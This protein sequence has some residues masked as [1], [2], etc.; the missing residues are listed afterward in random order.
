M[1]V[2]LLMACGE[3]EDTGTPEVEEPLP[4]VAWSF[5]AEVIDF[6]SVE[7]GSTGLAQVVLTNTGGDTLLLGDL[8]SMHEDVDITAPGVFTLKPDEEATLELSWSP[9]E[10]GT[11]DTVV[12]LEVGGGPTDFELIEM[13]VTGQADGADLQL[14]VEAIDFGTVTVGCT[15]TE[16]IELLNLGTTPLTLTDLSTDYAPEFELVHD[17]LPLTIEPNGLASLEVIYTPVQTTSNVT[18]LYIETDDPFE[19]VASIA[20]DGAGWIEADNEMYWEAKERQPLTILMNINEIAIYQT[21]AGKLKNSIETFFEQLDEFDVKFRM[22]CFL[23]ESGTHQVETETWIDDTMSYEESVDIFYEM[24]EGTSTYGDNDYNM[25]TLDAALEENEEWLFEGEFE[26]SKLNFFTINDDADASQLSASV[27]VNKWYG[28]KEDSE[29]IQV[30]AI[31]GVYEGG[32]TCGEVYF[33]NYDDAISLTGGVFL[34]ICE[35]DWT[36]HMIDV[37]NAFIGEIQQFELTGHPSASTIEVYWDGIPQFDG[38]EYDEEDNE[39]VFDQT[40][41]PPDGTTVRVYYIMATECPG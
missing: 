9:G 21:H 17:E 2:I 14:A 41:Y 15:G 24:L 40:S 19:P 12:W 26:D 8:G 11:L 29:D 33:N 25:Q 36:D 23:H 7:L 32:S 35:S 27:Y 16:T 4:D 20:V 10:T 34:D 38:W 13:D 37:A 18:T 6:G 39:V 22:A 31:A 30:H 28:Y 1:L 5:D 3:V